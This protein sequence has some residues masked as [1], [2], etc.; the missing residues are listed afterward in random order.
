[1]RE[2]IVQ[3]AIAI[4]SHLWPTSNWVRSADSTGLPVSGVLPRSLAETSFD[5]GAT[6]SCKAACACQM[7]A[8]SPCQTS[9]IPLSNPS[10][11]PFSAKRTQFDRGDKPGLA[12][13]RTRGLFAD[14]RPGREQIGL[15]QAG[16]HAATTPI[17]IQSH[18]AGTPKPHPRASAAVFPSGESAT[19]HGAMP[20]LICC[21]TVPLA[22]LTT[23]SLFAIERQ[24]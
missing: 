20:T 22:R 24:T 2:A 7:T 5:S 16:R 15:C 6:Y 13:S 12:N 21:A 9:G 17:T 11:K 4:R 23:P 1:M 8:L 14:C 18:L 19:S 3:L 10:D